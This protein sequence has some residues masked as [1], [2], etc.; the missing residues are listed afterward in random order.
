MSSITSG[1]SESRSTNITG[2]R[3]C[4]TY[5]HSELQPFERTATVVRLVSDEH[6]HFQ[7]TT[8]IT[9]EMPIVSLNV[10]FLSL[11]GTQASLGR[12]LRTGGLIV[13]WTGPTGR[14]TPEPTS[15]KYE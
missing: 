9:V 4:Y 1:S 7:P 5:V 2:G 3:T 14:I 11:T 10:S 12:S 13:D 15:G 6:F 8:R